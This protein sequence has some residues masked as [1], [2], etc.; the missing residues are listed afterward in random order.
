[1]QTYI[2]T[3]C[4]TGDDVQDRVEEIRDGIIDQFQSFGIDMHV[5]EAVRITPGN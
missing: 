2:F 4:L 3:V 1:M 5:T